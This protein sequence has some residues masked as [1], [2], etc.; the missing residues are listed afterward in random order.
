MI[1]SCVLTTILACAACGGGS[2]D[3][4]FEGFTPM[5]GTAV[6]L[7][8][9]SCDIPFVGQSA[10]SGIGFHFGSFPDACGVVTQTMMCGTKATST[11]VIGFVISGE[12]GAASIAPVGPGTYRFLSEPPTG[13]FLASV[14]EAAE[15]D[16]A[17][18]AGMEGALDQTGGTIRIAGVTSTNITGSF[19]VD[20]EDGTNF[21]HDFDVTICP[22]TLDIC[23]RF[24][25]GCIGMFTCVP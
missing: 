4:L 13:S 17:C 22:V 2:S 12:V 9:A 7:A 8:P 18:M 21:A 3:P 5:S 10:V 15:V 25:A 24:G 1:R 6:V 16:G 14:A 20:F 23:D 11:S 19:D